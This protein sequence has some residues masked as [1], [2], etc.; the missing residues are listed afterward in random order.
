MHHNES[1]GLWCTSILRWHM[2]KNHCIKWGIVFIWA[3]LLLAISARFCHDKRKEM[4]Q[5][6]V[7]LRFAVTS[8]TFVFDES[9]NALR[10]F[11]EKVYAYAD[12][13]EYHDVDA[14]IVNGNVTG[15]GSRMA[16]DAVEQIADELLRKESRLYTTMGEMDFQVG[17][18]DEVN[19]PEIKEKITDH[20]LS[21]K[22]HRFIFLSP[23]YDSYATKLEWLEQ[24]LEQ[25]AGTNGKP[26]F[27]FQYAALK[28]TF[29]GT[30]NWYT[31]ESEPIYQLLE[32]YDNVIDFASSSGSA[33]NTVRSIFQSN[34]TYVNT[35]VVS[36]M[37]MNYQEFG[38]DTS[39]EVITS[40]V[41]N[42]SQCRIVE[43][44]G[45]GKTVIYTMDLNT[46]NLYKMPDSEEILRHEVYAGIKETYCYTNGKNVS[47]D[48]PV[49]SSDD[50][51]EFSNVESNQAE[52]T[53]N[54]ASDKDGV[55]FYNIRVLN[56]SDNSMT[57]Y[58]TYSD[59]AQYLPATQ[60]TYLI[61]GLKPGETYHVEIVPYDLFGMA[62]TSLSADFETPQGK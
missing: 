47:G 3:V 36:Q 35:G 4:N 60:K 6:K 28:N 48:S 39:A 18:S 20:S 21:I 41:S 29:Y 61:S 24:Q 11:I 19:D 43:V 54:H 51:V 10:N 59:F 50:C 14:F 52:I 58:N 7:I 55:L 33:A 15:D 25:V 9:N 13:N 2:K 57:E 30:E 34:A 12:Q 38:H 1:N 27:V 16:F 56:K 5:D 17:E 49:F 53:F 31:M 23:I 22:G 62:G 42:V 37:R 8:K 32:Q 40:A 45:D 26:V 46:G 44:Y